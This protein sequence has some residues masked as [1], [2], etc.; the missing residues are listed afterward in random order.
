MILPQ[1]IKNEGSKKGEKSMKS[2]PASPRLR[3]TRAG[4]GKTKFKNDI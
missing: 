1:D 3:R 2:D 4:E